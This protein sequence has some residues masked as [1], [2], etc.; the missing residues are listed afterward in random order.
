VSKKFFL[1]PFN[2]AGE[3]VKRGV[4]TISAESS[5]EDIAKRVD[6]V[7]M[8]AG[9]GKI[10]HVEVK[11][12]KGVNISAWDVRK[13]TI[14]QTDGEG[15][16]EFEYACFP[17]T[18]KEPIMDDA[19][20]NE[21]PAETPAVEMTAE[22]KI[23]ADKAKRE[24]LKAEKLAEREAAKAGKAEEMAKVKAEKDAQKAQTAEQRAKEREE[25]KAAREA[26]RKAKA[27][28]RAA[29]ASASKPEKGPTKKDKVHDMISATGGASVDDIA[30][31]LNV[32]EV[33]ARSLISDLKRAGIAVTSA[34]DE[35]TKVT[36]YHASPR[37][38]AAAPAPSEAAGE[39]AE[40]EP[41]V[42]TETPVDP[43]PATGEE[44][45]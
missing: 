8:M 32:S 19:N 31:E 24:A 12:E 38:T 18:S 21:T 3:A 28:E 10:V 25:A 45:A 20:T 15:S 42:E 33:A 11:D 2:D 7:T 16:T 43:E 26:E 37:T 44:A 41:A 36:K 39:S 1:T 4:V 40:A 6:Q 30:T 27:E 17:R 9:I 22:E 13:E 35:G 23:A 29:K 5:Q 14:V 34:K